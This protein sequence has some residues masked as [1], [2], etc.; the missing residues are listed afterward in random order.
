MHTLP[1]TKDNLTLQHRGQGEQPNTYLNLG[2]KYSK[3][4]QEYVHHR[5]KEEPFIRFNTLK[6]EPYDIVTRSSVCCAEGVGMCLYRGLR[7]SATSHGPHK[8][9]PTIVLSDFKPVAISIGYRY[10]TTYGCL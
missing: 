3:P 4:Y 8:H 10:L 7:R 1:P 2:H 6:A 5:V 9:I